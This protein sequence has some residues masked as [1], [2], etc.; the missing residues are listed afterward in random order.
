VVPALRIP[1][2]YIG[3]T[4]PN[5]QGPN[6]QAQIPNP[7]PVG[8]V[9]ESLLTR[10]IEDDELT[11]FERTTLQY[12]KWGFWAAIIT[13]L[14]AIGTGR[15]F[16]NQFKEMA[17]QTDISEMVAKQ[18]RI[19]AKNA[20]LVTAKQ[21]D[22]AQDSVNAIKRQ[23]RQD[24]RPWI[25]VGIPGFKPEAVTIGQPLAPIINIFSTGKTPGALQNPFGS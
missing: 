22:I 14:V 10:V 12:A 15:I 16:F 13:L 2:P 5:N 24:Q 17:F 8:L 9:N 18:A 23:M 4:P 6:N 20:A 7:L 3:P 1:F 25:K 19:D 21:L 11:G